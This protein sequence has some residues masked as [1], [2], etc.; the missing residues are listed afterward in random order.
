MECGHFENEDST[1][2]SHNLIAQDTRSQCE[3]ENLQDPL[4]A[5][6]QGV[7]ITGSTVP[8]CTSVIDSGECAYGINCSFILQSQQS[9]IVP[10]V[11]FTV[12]KF[13]NSE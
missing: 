2:N 12:E 10:T 9:E 4:V 13:T 5:W 3:P 11:G 6:P 7:H 1:Y 8:N